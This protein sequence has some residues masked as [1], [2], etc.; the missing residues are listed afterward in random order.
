MQKSHELHQ[1]IKLHAYLASLPRLCAIDKPST[2]STTTDKTHLVQVVALHTHGMVAA[3]VQERVQ[4]LRRRQCSD[5]ACLLAASV[6]SA[7]WGR[8]AAQG[9]Q[10]CC[11]RKDAPD[12]TKQISRTS[13]TRFVP[14]TRMQ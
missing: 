8:L 7:Q 11:G 2:K 5:A 14:H 13:R 9:T 6:G 1:T 4:Q 10:K 12:Q 3:W